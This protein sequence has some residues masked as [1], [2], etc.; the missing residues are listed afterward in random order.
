MPRLSRKYLESNFLHLIIQGINQEYI[1]QRNEW[2]SI[3]LNIMK[4]KL[5]NLKIEIIAYCIMGNHAHFLLY[6]ENINDLLTLMRKVNTTY[7]IRCNKINHRKGYV[8]RDRYF[9][10]QIFT[11]NQLYH[12]IV[13]IHK[14]PLAAGIVNCY[15]DYL[16][17]SFHEYIN[18]HSRK[19]LTSDGLKLV[20]GTDKD[21]GDLFNLLHEVSYNINNIADV[22]NFSTY[23]DLIKKYQEQNRKTLEEIQKDSILF[24]NLL[25]ELRKYCGM[26]LR[27]MSNVFNINKDKLNKYIHVVID[28]SKD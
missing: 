28:A 22:I 19:F 4:D 20:F 25:L 15:Q 13:Y 27:E 17:S 2:K 24:G 7:A 21:Y 11:E 16:F 6:Y 9:S 26:S 1:F 14:N 10:Q 23:E 12:C 8:F 5:D 18:P 3:Y